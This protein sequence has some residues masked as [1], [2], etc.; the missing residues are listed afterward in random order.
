MDSGA[1]LV[2]LHGGLILANSEGQRLLG[3]VRG[4]LLEHLEHHLADGTHPSGTGVLR[5]NGERHEWRVKPCYALGQRSFLISLTNRTRLEGALRQL[6]H[7]ERLTTV[8]ELLTGLAHELN[9]PLTSIGLAVDL[10]HEQRAAASTD[11][12]ERVQHEGHRLRHMVKRLLS[13]ARAETA[14]KSQI[15]PNQVIR[16]TMGILAPQLRQVRIETH[17][18]LQT[19]L[20]AVSG[21]PIELQQIIVNLVINAMHALK[22]HPDN[23]RIT[24][25]TRQTGDKVKIFVSDTGPGISSTVQS[26][27]FE[28]FFTTKP[29]GEGTGLGL[30]LSRRIAR[31]NGGDLTVDSKLGFGCRFA[32]EIPLA[33]STAQ[34]NPPSSAT[35]SGTGTSPASLFPAAPVAPGAGEP[36][37]EATGPRP[38]ASS[39]P[40]VLVVDDEE[41]LGALIVELLEGLGYEGT[42]C[43]NGHE[44]LRCLESSPSDAIMTD[45]HMPGLD[46]RELF[47]AIEARYPTLRSKVIFMTGDTASSDVETFLR[48][49]RAPHIDKPFTL[50][51]L[52][53]VLTQVAPPD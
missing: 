27:I 7:A 50:S 17:L 22:D 44:A 11:L 6:N 12:L 26:H 14:G 35:D 16:D 38:P 24:L 37:P 10:L 1:L 33:E 41:H 23:R 48:E 21:D 25:G 5:T 32:L 45:V 52:R 20:P 30:S 40:K 47:E 53:D 15:D 31:E 19:P 49:S 8:G 46:G 36:N 3:K 18:R 29:S 28:P 43:L 13:F 4:S 34:A 51:D 42:H 39:R 9:N 2:N